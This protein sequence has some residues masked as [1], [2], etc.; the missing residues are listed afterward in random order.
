MCW[1]KLLRFKLSMLGRG[2]QSLANI[3]IEAS[4]ALQENGFDFVEK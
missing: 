3:F 1:E 2:L 4:K